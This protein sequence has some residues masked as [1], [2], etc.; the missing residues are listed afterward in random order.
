MAFSG[1]RLTVAGLKEHK[2]LRR[3]RKLLRA[4]GWRALKSDASPAFIELLYVSPCG[5]YVCKAATDHRWGQFITWAKREPHANLPVV[6]KVCQWENPKDTY[7]T[8][9]VAVMERLDPLPFRGPAWNYRPAK[10]ATPAMARIVR[11][12]RQFT[13]AS[14]DYDS[15]RVRGKVYRALMEKMRAA[16]GF[17]GDLHGYNMMMRQ[18]PRG[19]VALVLLDP[20]S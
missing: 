5:K 19:G 15:A 10:D 13:D 14:N 6:H 16:L 17:P 7:D 2:R 9:Y 18:G 4:R 1:E 11:K 20:Y 12:A 8:L 3:L